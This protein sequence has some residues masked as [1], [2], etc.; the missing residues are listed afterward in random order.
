[1]LTA[2][3]ESGLASSSEWLPGM[4]RGKVLGL[5]NS[6]A[7]AAKPGTYLQNLALAGDTLVL[8]DIQRAVDTE[9][10]HINLTWGPNEKP[11]DGA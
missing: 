2:R 11:E 1:M 8:F 6:E 7:I 5:F 4:Q 9:A 10:T 3:I